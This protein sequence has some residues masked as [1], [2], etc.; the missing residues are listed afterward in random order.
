MST[1]H[2]N[3]E[4]GTSKG[5][6]VED[7]AREQNKS[8]WQLSQEEEEATQGGDEL[9]D[10]NEEDGDVEGTTDSGAGGATTG[11]DTTDG[12]ELTDGS[13]AKKR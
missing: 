13:Q 1:G 3:E 2:H 4:A 7:E 8:F 9:Y 11:G 6:S 12:G 5:R 10:P